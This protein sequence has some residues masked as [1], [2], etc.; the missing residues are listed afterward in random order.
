MYTIYINFYNSNFTHIWFPYDN[1][2]DANAV[3]QGELHGYLLTEKIT[4]RVL[5]I[6]FDAQT[7]NINFATQK[8]ECSDVFPPR[9]HFL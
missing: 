9:N 6:G 2:L 7:G 3:K 4:D 1:K 8:G 5:T